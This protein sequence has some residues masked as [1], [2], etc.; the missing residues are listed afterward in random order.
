MKLTT[1]VYNNKKFLFATIVLG[2]IFILLLLWDGDTT[3]LFQEKREVCDKSVEEEF[4]DVNGFDC[5]DVIGIDCAEIE[6][7]TEED[8]T[9]NYQLPDNFDELSFEEQCDEI[10]KYEARNEH[11]YLD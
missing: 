4:Y 11:K 5:N 9:D 2:V 3:T 1:S 8:T 6:Y 10:V 7:K